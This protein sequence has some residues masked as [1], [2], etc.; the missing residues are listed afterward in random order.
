MNPSKKN[1][2]LPA[3]IKPAY[4]IKQ[5]GNALYLTTNAKTLKLNELD[6][7]NSDTLI[8]CTDDLLWSL[9]CDFKLIAANNSFIKGLKELTGLTFK[10]G[11]NLLMK[12]VFEEGFLTFW[13]G[14]YRKALLGES[15][16]KEL[17]TPAFN[18]WKESWTDTSFNPVYKNNK[19]VGIACYSKNITENKLAEEK[20]RQCETRLIEAQEVAKVGSWET[21]LVTLKVIW[22]D[23]TY[24][25]FEI[26]PTL[27]QASHPGFLEFV[28]PED[29]AKVDAAFVSSINGHSINTV[30]HRIITKNGCI[31]IV[32]ERWRIYRDGKGLPTR[33]VGTCQDITERKNAELNTR[34]SEEK[35][36]MIMNAALDAIICIDVNGIITFWNPEAE[37]IFGWNEN[38][39][40]GQ[41]LSELI[42][43]LQYRQRH[44]EGMAHYLKTGN[45]PA[46]NKLLELSAI[47]RYKEEFPIELTI[48]P[49]K[50]GGEEFFCAFIR[51]ITE[52]KLSDKALKLAYDE[53]NTILE[54]IADA[55]FAVNKNW[56]VTYWNK[57][58][59]KLLH[60]PK[61]KILGHHLWQVFS[62]SIDSESYKKYHQAI[63][64]NQTINFE[65]YYLSLDKWYEITAYPSPDGLSVYFK[66]ITERKKSEAAVKKAYEEKNSVLES[67]DDGF[68]AIDNNSLVTYWNSKA[69]IL[70]G[71]KREDTIG[72]N[73]HEMFTSPDSMVFYDNYQ[74]AIRENTTVHFEAFSKRA[75]K[76]FA[77]SAFASNNGLSVHFKDITE[78]K[79]SEEKIKES[80]L[81]YRSLIEQATD[82]ICITDQS[83]KIIDMNPVGCQMS[84]YSKEE[85][86]QLTLPDIL[87]KEDLVANPF[88][89]DE[90]AAGKII[91]NER[92]LKRKD[93]TGV[94]MEISTKM[95]LDGRFVMFGRDITAQKKATEL[96]IKSEA[97]Y[98]TLFEQNMA[99]IYQSTENGV[100][101]SC[102]N[103]FAKML[104]YDSPD[105]LL[106]INASA[107]YFSPAERNDFT[108]KV[109]TQQKINNYESVLKCK[110]G[111]PLS[112]IENI[113]LHKDDITGEA[114]FDGIMIDITE[115]KQGELLLKES[116][117]RYNLISR[118]TND[119]VWDWDLVT[120]KVYRNK[121]GWKK[122]FRTGDN[123]IE[124]EVIDDWD[125][126][127]HPEDRHTV[128][129]VYDEIQ[130]LEKDF[131][132]VECR[133]LRDDGTYAYIHDRGNIIRNAEGKAIRLLGATQDITQRKEAEL[134]V[135]KSELRFRLLVQDGSDLI[136]ILDKRG[137]YLYSNPGAVRILGYEP[138][139]LAGKNAY[140]FI[141][142]DD[143][144]IM[145][146][147]LAKTKTGKHLELK[148]FRFK[149]TQG[150]WRWLESKVTDM[151]DNPDVQGYIFN[152]R[153]VTE[154]IIA[155]EEIEKLSI[156]ARE[157]VNA[158]I[159]TDAEEKILWVNEAFTRITEFEPEDVMG[160]KPGDFLQ[161]DETNL[162]VVRFM[163][164]KIK[165]ILPF[166]C[167]IVNYSKFG[168]RYWL[169]IQCQ[170]Q[171][172][173]AGKLKYFFAIE[174]DITKEKEAE[175]ILKASEERYRHLFN[176]NPAGIFI[177]DLD[178]FQILEINNTAVGLYGYSREEFLTKTAMDLSL[179]E[180]YDKIK[181]FAAIARQKFDFKSEITCKHINNLGE[182]MYVHIGSHRIQ[183][184]GRSAILAL[185]TNITDK[186]ILEKILEEERLVKQKEI[187]TAVISAQEQERQELGSELHDNINQILAGSLL[188]LGLTK[189]AL[190]NENPY[191]DETEVLINSAIGEIRKLSHSLIPPSLNESEFLEALENM[192]QL[193]QKASGIIINLQA[194]GFDETTIT[195]KLKLNIY[196][197]VQE[198]LNNILKHASAQKVIVRLVRDD[199][200][201]LLSIK[202]DGV[203]FDTSKKAN[204]V[205]LMNIKTRAALFNGNVNI[206]SSEGRGCELRVLFG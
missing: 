193:T 151:S 189:R 102:N 84:G 56:I 82:A 172:D 200:K 99:G 49:I 74:K 25:I 173:E 183:F 71:E 133:V 177:W 187:T 108:S 143:A 199:E 179:T 158:V 120:G 180:D 3:S 121:E 164:N 170:P 100:I 161:G 109:I 27:L 46:L 36:S 12:G 18:N 194:F 101:L 52:R 146:A 93:G 66:D 105:E 186:V 21:D 159:I 32:E 162:A 92:K 160:K 70:M 202:D 53:K 75:D 35:R 111:S 54:S 95:M 129:M 154:R 42:I 203:G 83:M 176:N 62:D 1:I 132:E 16:K 144:I 90:I 23:E 190:E 33:A 178:N 153:D 152:S 34:N 19:V 24:R 150:E 50:Q 58:A 168:R 197:I 113:S 17:Y 139:M 97:K 91:R 10:P 85:L 118:A 191:I 67:I 51:D 123:E 30:E 5:R 94:E 20:I 126:R 59:E 37:K 135:V 88:K 142:P 134:Q 140:A 198:Q 77:V 11:D 107:L 47:N 45:G 163:R 145:K 205:G 63:E 57:E 87:F 38:E 184:K 31:K 175:E 13:E 8:N 156:I 68:F 7:N 201:T 73:L 76:W 39:V 167:D 112:F 98:R 195:D 181:Q 69:E 104:K 6:K 55:F 149:N 196:R 96:I 182:E 86:L 165:K 206:I 116:N 103:A 185:T 64:T 28:H 41:L 115:K 192:I 60:T 15:F 119:M 79:N 174:T 169:R 188:Y 155:E 48:M 110:D 65:D 166:E 78:R 43:P 44:N 114:I 81:R 72:R 157:T 122:I 124:N 141:H 147:D 204:G 89:M 2:L 40:M 138:E 9:D 26:D 171:F 125:N 148:P 117:E 106:K 14:C 22:S 127:I 137:Y 29:R 128:K 4:K 61:N 80:E 130:K 131:F 136:N